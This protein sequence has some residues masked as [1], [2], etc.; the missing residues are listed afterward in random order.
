MGCHVATL[1]KKICLNIALMYW[2]EDMFS[3]STQE[4]MFKYYYCMMYWQEIMFSNSTQG[5]KTT[6]SINSR[7]ENTTMGY[8][9]DAGTST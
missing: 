8:I 1:R 5:N 9:L 4:D 3:N 2:Q 6:G 7:Q